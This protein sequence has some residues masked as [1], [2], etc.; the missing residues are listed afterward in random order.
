MSRRDYKNFTAGEYYHVFNRGNNK[1][2]VFRDA[3]DYSFFLSR[4]REAL[5]PDVLDNAHGAHAQRYYPR[6]KLPAD[7][8]DLVAYCLMPNHFHFLLLQK[9]EISISSL[10]LKVISGYV[11]YV[12][13]KYQRVGSLFQDQCKAT[14]IADDAQLIHTSSYIHCNPVVAGLSTSLGDYAYDSYRE[15]M[16][17]DNTQRLSIPESVLMHFPHPK[18]Y[19]EFALERLARLQ[20]EKALDMMGEA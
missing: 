5:Y 14:H 4:L 12:N 15:Y 8:F 11:K 1:G 3:E 6:K 20:Q 9:G 7:S 10:M 13:K 2:E 16:D 17:T 19:E 18:K